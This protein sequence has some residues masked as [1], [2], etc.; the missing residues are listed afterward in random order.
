[1]HPIEDIGTGAA[2]SH[3][4]FGRRRLV[5]VAPADTI[6]E[7]L[8]D[9][10]R[11]TGWPY[12]PVLPAAPIA[13]PRAAYAA[14][15][16]LTTALVDLV[17]RAA[18][19]SADTT[20][21]RLAAY[22]MPP[23]ESQLFTDD[24]FAEERYADWVARP[25]IVVGRDGPRFLEFN[26]SAAIGGPV[27][28]HCRLAVWRKLYADDEG[29]VPFSYTDPFAA[30]AEMFRSLSAELGVAPRVAMVGSARDQ[31]V[32]STRYFDIEAEYFNN[33]GL[34]ARFF[35]PESLHHAWDCPPHLRYPLGLR[36]FT[37]PDWTELGID[38][39]PVQAALDHGCMLVDTQTST[40]L[41]SKLT[42]GLLS[43]GRPW[44]SAA[45]RA[46]VA[47]YL[48]WTRIL[49][50]RRTTWGDRDVDLI[51]FSIAS[52]ELLV[53]KNSLGMSGDQVII[54]RQ[55][56][57]PEW[58]A[59]VTEAA[60]AGT[61]VVQAFV[62]PQSCRLAMIAD[63]A[64]EPHDV[65]IAPVFGPML[66]GG[67]PAG[68]FSRFFGDGTAGIVSAFLGGADNCVVAI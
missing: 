42:M 51:P 31:G 30:R 68:M 64:N 36:N 4:W 63:G 28:T 39:T 38:T 8:R 19:E 25:D 66:F 59:A 3:S 2:G 44:M 34:T 49:G 17:R 16:R 18:L 57:Q 45:E 23:S 62:M 12:Q 13:L 14:L 27:E 55:A 40:F 7:M 47:T 56:S 11:D 9:E 41:S 52:R 26:I 32:K 58:D 6:R 43:E 46:L 33:A 54:G 20:A 65:D 1:M 50:E 5:P 10:I 61:S 15:F 29:R 60:Q 48:P 37:I 53:L 35:E 21:G 22:K 67:R 24:Q